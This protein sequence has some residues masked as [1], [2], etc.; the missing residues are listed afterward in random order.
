MVPSRRAA[1]HPFVD[2]R[3]RWALS[4]LLLYMGLAVATTWPLV[5]H[6]DSIPLHRQE[7]STVPNALAWGL[8]WNAD[9]VGHFYDEYWQAPIFH[10]AEDTFAYSEAMPMLGALSAP[11]F[12]M[13]ASPEQAYSWLLLF[14][15]FTNG[16]VGWI[17]LGRFKIH[18]LI[19][20][21][22][23]ALIVLLPYS[24]REIG[25]LPLVPLAGVLLT[26]HALFGAHEKPTYGR[27][28]LAGAALALTF[29]L[30][31]Q[32]ALMFAVA[33]VP[34]LILSGRKDLGRL[35]AAGIVATLL[36]V[37]VV[38]PVALGQRAAIE[39]HGFERPADEVRHGAASP[40]SWVRS[41][42][43]SL[44][45]EPGKWSDKALFPGFGLLLLAGF[46]VARSRKLERRRRIVMFLVTLAISAWLLSVLPKIVLFGWSP[47]QLF[48]WIPG[49][50][51]LR[52]VWRFGML[53]HV[54]L[55]L[56]AAFGLHAVLR[57]AWTRWGARPAIGVCTLVALVMA[58]ELWPPARALQRHEPDPVSTFIEQNTEPDDV[59]AHIPFPENGASMSLA[60]EAEAMRLQTEHGRRIVNGYSS[61]F[62][63][64]WFQLLANTR[65]FPAPHTL[66]L[67]RSRGVDWIV[68]R[69]DAELGT[70][71]LEIVFDDPRSAYR[72]L[73]LTRSP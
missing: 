44:P 46:G 36:A 20:L 45:A 54:A 27:V 31:A 62:P 19:R 7:L 22:G 67:L 71:S 21:F 1:M 65:E 10:P 26:M 61:Y 51:Q 42:F 29:Y 32:H 14:A 50:A 5:Q 30:C 15:L 25:V 48:A 18:P 68:V 4:A 12:A 63:E 33:A 8:W 41:P 70:G 58:A 24:Q 60:S 59:L 37:A 13:G 23:G 56:L 43:R 49:M 9:R 66:R 11:L 28:L 57:E 53:V 6:D 34:A 55:G 64:G 73:R 35:A 16:L 40:L 17:V 47:W 39:A 72:V 2:P 38:V 69:N 3:S 52:G